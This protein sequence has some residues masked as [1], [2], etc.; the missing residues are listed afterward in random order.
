[1]IAPLLVAL[2]L[3]QPQQQAPQAQPRDSTPPEAYYGV[4]EW[5]EARAKLEP[6]MEKRGFTVYIIGDMEGL[7]AAVRNGTEMRPPTRGGGSDHEL[8]RAELTDEINAVI[9]GAR[10]AGATQF[11]VNEGHG[12]TLFRNALP[13]RLDSE[14]ILIRGYPKPIVMSTGLNP[15]VDLLIIVG[16]HANAGTPGIISHSFAFD[17]FTVNGRQLNEAGIAAFI[18]GEL[19]VPMGLA[20]GDQILTEET[21]RMLGPIET[22]T[23]KLAMS[24]SAGAGFSPAHV[25][26]E[27]RTAAARAVRRA[28]AGELKPLSL[29]RPYQV[30][31][32]IRR[33]FD[34][35]FVGQIAQLK[36]LRLESGDRCFAYTSQSAEAIGDLLNR[37]EWIVLKP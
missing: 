23:T 30:R 33:S 17:S 31:L 24:R 19:G 26:R 5:R 28:K 18:G 34:P 37:I 6:L 22:V 13:E 32:C 16:A 11:V 15:D 10:D 9:A 36:G 27:L 8:F 14:A 4:T 1:M 20:A 3:Q 7:A 2:A 35:W 29:A 12:G 25:H 21:R